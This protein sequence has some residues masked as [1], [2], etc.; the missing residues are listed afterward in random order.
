MVTRGHASKKYPITAGAPEGSVLGPAL[1]ILFAADIDQCLSH[2]VT[3]SSL[4]DDSIPCTADQTK[5]QPPGKDSI[6]T[7]NPQQSYRMRA[8]NVGS[9]FPLPVLA[10]LLLL[11]LLSSSS[12][13]SSSLSSWS[14]S[15]SSSSSSSFLLLFSLPF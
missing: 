2:G 9:I 4:A 6:F 10:L 11:L 3:L 7:D 5:V 8:S 1:F 15:S 13:S 12:S 14:S